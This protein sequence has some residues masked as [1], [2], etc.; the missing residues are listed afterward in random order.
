MRVE[1]SAAY[2]GTVYSTMSAISDR[3]LILVQAAKDHL[4]KYGCLDSFSATQ[5]FENIYGTVD[6]SC[7]SSQRRNFSIFDLFHSP[8]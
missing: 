1:R 2:R 5:K 3:Q 7:F 6:T 4:L 8:A